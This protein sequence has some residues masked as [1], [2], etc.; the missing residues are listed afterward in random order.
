MNTRNDSLNDQQTKLARALD[1]ASK[2]F[3]VACEYQ[4]EACGHPSR[5][6]I[7]RAQS[8]AKLALLASSRVE[9]LLA[10]VVE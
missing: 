2:A 9:S 8:N 10:K 6:A 1:S 4:S 7:E 5:E 3:K